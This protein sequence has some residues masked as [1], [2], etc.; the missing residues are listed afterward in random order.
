MQHRRPFK[1]PLALAIRREQNDSSRNTG[2]IAMR[3]CE[4]LLLAT[5]FWVIGSNFPDL[6]TAADGDS[7]GMGFESEPELRL[8][9]TD[10]L[11][12]IDQLE[13]TVTGAA[14][15]DDFGLIEPNPL[16]GTGQ[17]LAC[18]PSPA[19]NPAGLPSHYVTYEKGWTLRPHDAQSTPFEL[20]FELHNQFRYTF[21]NAD[22]EPTFDAS[23]NRRFV[24]DRNDFD[25]NR[26]RFVFTGYAFDPDLGYYVNIDYSTVASDSIQPL[27]AWISFRTSERMTLY[28]GLGKVP[29]TWEWQQTSRYTLG[30]DRSLAT[31][32]FRP[33]ISAG[34]WANGNL[35]D[36]LHYTAFVGDGYNTLT[37]RPSELDTRLV[38]SALSWWEPQG[39]FGVGF[40]DLENHE[41]LSM[42]IGHGLTQTR[43]ESTPDQTPGPEG[44]VIRLSDGTRLVQEG[45]LRPGESVNAFDIWLYT[46]HLGIKRSGFS[47]SGEY[48]M[49][50]LRNLEGTLGS[51]F[52]SI[53]D[54]GFFAQS[55]AFVIPQSLEVFVRGSQVT[56]EHGSGHEISAG[57]NWYLFGARN[58]RGTF[59]VTS[60][61][62]SPAEQSR[63]GYVAGG[64]GTLFRVQ[65]WTFF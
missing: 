59:E 62:D 4:Y 49:R 42:R 20:R 25:I 37:L 24:S 50:W 9:L 22:G 2:C 12:R 39:D 41:S 16:D 53:F 14:T 15:S 30:V 63:T 33:S 35:T 6:S 61:E 27:L 29:G 13:R 11:T 32:F 55:S 52:Q 21:L 57:L 60:L 1:P 31:T 19:S 26:G 58:A 28:L 45:A 3:P 10:A 48:Y 8:A 43:N 40:S 38:Y 23:G 64:S 51:D 65:L 46:A 54:H 47:L 34:V 56:G 17:R 18:M 36:R 7:V 5:L 44:T